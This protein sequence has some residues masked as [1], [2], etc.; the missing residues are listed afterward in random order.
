MDV[1]FAVMF[2]KIGSYLMMVTIRMIHIVCFGIWIQSS[3]VFCSVSLILCMVN[4]S[5]LYVKV[6]VVNNLPTF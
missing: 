3:Q 1:R 5:A 4:P 2:G 6:I